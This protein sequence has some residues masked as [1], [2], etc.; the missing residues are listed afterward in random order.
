MKWCRS[1]GSNFI[2]ASDAYPHAFITM[3]TRKT[4]KTREVSGSGRTQISQLALSRAQILQLHQ[5]QGRTNVCNRHWIQNCFVFPCSL[6]I[7]LSFLHKTSS[8]KLRERS[9]MSFYDRHVSKSLVRVN[10]VTPSRMRT[11]LWVGS[12]ALSS[13]PWVNLSVHTVLEDLNN[14]TTCMNRTVR[15]FILHST[16]F[17]LILYFI[18]G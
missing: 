5:L 7:L 2:I 3:I 17:E 18:A 8:N 9:C 1:I 13:I 15:D 10:M 12:A 14:R 4:A 16:I 11:M 6:A